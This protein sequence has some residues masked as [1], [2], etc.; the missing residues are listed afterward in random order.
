MGSYRNTKIE[1][2]QLMK[3]GEGGMKRYLMLGHWLESDGEKRRAGRDKN[4]YPD[5][6]GRVIV[7]GDLVGKGFFAVVECEGPVE[8]YMADLIRQSNVEIQPVALCPKDCNW[9]PPFVIPPL[10]EKM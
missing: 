7:A 3:V 9:C 1:F 8:D 5:G 4:F 6:E 2:R 10:R